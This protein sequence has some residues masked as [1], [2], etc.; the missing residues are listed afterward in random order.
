MILQKM[1]LGWFLYPEHLSLTV[2]H[3]HEILS[4]IRL[5]LSKLLFQHG[6]NILFLVSIIAFIYLLAKKSIPKYSVH[7]L[8][9]STI[10]IV[11]YIA[12]SSLNFFTTR[13]LLSVLPFYIIPCSWL[14]TAWLKRNWQKASAVIAFVLIFGFFSFVA[15]NHNE[16]DTSP[17]YKNTV[18]LQKQAVNFA[19]DMH[20]Q[21]KS[22]YT[23]FLMQ[24]Y[25]SIPDLGYLDD[26]AHPFMN[27]SNKADKTY[28][29]Y[30]FCSN[31]NDPLIRSL[32]G[33]SGLSLI[34]RF[35]SDGAWVEWYAKASL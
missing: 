35:E 4:R 11:F 29:L 22:I 25:L 20:W 17:G 15:D 24:Y 23:A 21:Q 18:L 6:R 8:L 16:Q 32:P 5:F 13:Y 27:I 19:E 2:L 31:E 7:L 10:F 12:F 26:K 3:P 34:K 28:D 30:L 1:K 14:I 9:F 33:D